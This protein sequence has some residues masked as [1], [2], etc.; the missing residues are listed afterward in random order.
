MP[1]LWR[2]TWIPGTISP[3]SGA[4]GRSTS[5]ST[6]I[7]WTRGQFWVLTKADRA[8]PLHRLRRIRVPTLALLKATGVVST[9]PIGR[10]G[11][12]DPE[13]QQPSAPAARAATAAATIRR[14]RTRVTPVVRLLGRVQH[15]ERHRPDLPRA[16]V[17]RGADADQQQPRSGGN[18]ERDGP[19]R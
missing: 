11:S 5:R 9:V 8:A 17:G 2:R 13:R 6:R 15:L 7:S 3:G 16:A 18:P 4:L 10:T 1:T 19:R 14:S 12:G